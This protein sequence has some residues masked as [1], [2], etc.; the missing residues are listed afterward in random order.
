[1]VD[2]VSFVQQGVD[3]GHSLKIQIHR[4][5][6][7]R[8]KIKPEA[9]DFVLKKLPYTPLHLSPQKVIAY[10]FPVFLILNGIHSTAWFG[11]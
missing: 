3:V 11:I 8:V 7:G 9:A 10:L 2:P 4:L 6:V 5:K 1:M